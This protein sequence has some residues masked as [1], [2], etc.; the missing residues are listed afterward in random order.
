[1]SLITQTVPLSFPFR[2]CLYIFLISPSRFDN[3]G[4]MIIHF[5]DVK[6]VGEESERARE[7]NIW[8]T[9][10]ALCL[11]FTHTAVIRRKR[12][13]PRQHPRPTG[14]VDLWRTRYIRAT[15]YNI[16]VCFPYTLSPYIIITCV[17]LRLRILKRR[18]AV[19]AR[20][21]MKRVAGCLWP[22]VRSN[23]VV[24]D[25]LPHV[26]C[27]FSFAELLLFSNFRT[28]CVTGTTR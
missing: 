24:L 13:S 17:P 20:K 11:A 25:S 21:M 14:Y 10:A 27:I 1:M 26:S 15:Y 7:R 8:N 3:D 16:V 22:S 4:S 19:W 12:R 28:P 18:G 6:G 2:H 5:P 23:T 9:V